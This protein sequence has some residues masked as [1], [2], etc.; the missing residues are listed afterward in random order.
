MHSLLI[1][2]EH[3]L[4]DESELTPEMSE[5]LTDLLIKFQNVFFTDINLFDLNGN[6]LATSRPKIFS[7]GLVS[8]KMNAAAYNQLKKNKQFLFYHEE[9][10]GN[11][12]YISVYVPFRN[13][14]NEHIAYLN[15]PYFA[16]FLHNYFTN[17]RI[18]WHSWKGHLPPKKSG[19]L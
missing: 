3:K 2:L 12:E 15:L 11:M 6:L 13:N 5:Y 8:E 7:E 19:K 10:I 17:N 18:R 1:E 16:R 9:R 14:R 4:A